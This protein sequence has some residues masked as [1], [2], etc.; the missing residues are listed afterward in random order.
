MQLNLHHLA[1]CALCALLACCCT[2]DAQWREAL[3]G[4]QY[5]FPRDHGNHPDFKTEWWYFTGNVA[6]PDGKQ[7]GYQLTFFRQ[8]V[9]PPGQK[10]PPSSFVTRDVKFAHF[11]VS[12]LSNNRF[13]HF[14][15]LSRGSFGQ[16]GFEDSTRL[17]WIEN[18]EARITGPHSF[19][20]AAKQDGVSI[21]LDLESLKPPVFHGENGVSQK[22]EGVGR[23]S[24]YYSLTRLKTSGTISIDGTTHPVDGLSWF[25]HEWATNQLAANQKGWD[26]I[27]LQFDDGS[28]LMLFQI[29]TIDGGRDAYSSGTFIDASGK[30]EKIANADFSLTP[31]EWWT[32]PLSKGKYPVDW[33]IQI[34]KLSLDLTL[35]AANKAQELDA[36]PFAYWE[37]AITA[38]GTRTNQP[39]SA[40]GYLEMT[41][42]AGAVTG[43]QSR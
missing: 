23:A 15:K 5:E 31:V 9:I 40:R 12:E 30:S 20:L 39:V 10:T 43:M 41:G 36:A 2:A 3:P 33:K 24:H 42:Y 25:D 4:W 8:G 29:R 7:F 16:A 19:H 17:A 27:S 28:E 18:W 6:T 26:W 22:A 13:H 37:G 38:A 21:S 34:P 14:Q 35:R 1:L 32:S 11:A